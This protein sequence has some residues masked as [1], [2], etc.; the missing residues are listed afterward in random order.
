MSKALLLNSL[1]DS[2]YCIPLI[3]HRLFRQAGKQQED[4]LTFEIWKERYFNPAAQGGRP[5]RPGGSQQV[6]ARQALVNEGF[7]NVEN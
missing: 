7:K 4:I 5:G 2:F 1:I 6:A 3:L